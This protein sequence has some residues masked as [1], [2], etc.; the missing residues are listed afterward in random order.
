MVN[1]DN[2]LSIDLNVWQTQAEYA[3]QTGYKLNTISQWVKRDLAGEGSKKIDTMHI[4]Q[5]SITL[6]RKP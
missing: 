2:I 3:R 5:L 6:V 1:N 4:P